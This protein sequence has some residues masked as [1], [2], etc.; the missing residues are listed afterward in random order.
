MEQPVD[1]TVIIPLSELRYDDVPTLFGEYKRGLDM[2]GVTYE[3]VYVI[4]GDF[5]KA[6]DALQKLRATGEKF[7]IIQLAKHFGEATALNVAFEHTKGETI[8]TLPPYQQIEAEA[9]PRLLE[10]LRESDMVVARRWPRRDTGFNLLQSLLFNRMLRSV[11]DLPLH[12]IGCGARALKREI[13][14]EVSIYGD[15]HRFLPILAHQRGF[16][17]IEIDA[18]QASA[19]IVRQRIYEPGVYVRRM[20]DLLVVFFL[21]RFTKKPLRFFGL[22]GGSTFLVGFVVMSYIVIERILGLTALSERPALLLSSLLMVLGIQILA[23][24]LLGEIIIFTHTRELKEYTVA[25]IVN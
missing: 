4:D 9:I 21:T 10:G 13:L 15:Q 6:V 8:L 2:T 24:G 22:L 23:I 18:A 5:P 7:K 20:L 3:V 25:K 19:D 16:K 12:D 1:L 17:V 14:N 11:S